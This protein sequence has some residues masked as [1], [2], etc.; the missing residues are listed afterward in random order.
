M[1][2]FPSDCAY[3]FLVVVEYFIL[4]FCQCGGD[5]LGE[6]TVQVPRL[7]VVGRVGVLFLQTVLIFT[8]GSMGY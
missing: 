1:L 8:P 2:V 5:Q 3:T 7:S 6:M 4:C